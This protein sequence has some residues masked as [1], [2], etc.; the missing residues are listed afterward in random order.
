M[1]MSFSSSPLR[2]SGAFGVARTIS[3]LRR[4]PRR[5]R[6]EGEIQTNGFDAEIGGLVVGKMNGAGLFGAHEDVPDGMARLYSGIRNPLHPQSEGIGKV[7][8]GP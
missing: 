6:V 7:S 4:H 5:L 8:L 1:E 3:R 2:I